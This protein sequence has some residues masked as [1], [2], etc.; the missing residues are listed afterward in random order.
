MKTWDHKKYKNTINGLSITDLDGDITV[1]SDS[2]DFTFKQGQNGKTE[3][4]AN[5][6]MLI[7]ITVPFMATS[8]QL[9][10]IE[11]MRIAD[12]DAAV[13]PFPWASAIIGGDY[14]LFGSA[15]IESIDPPNASIEATARNVVLKVAVE[16]EFRGR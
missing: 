5:R 8:P 11:A 12:L 14:K 4:S 2:P 15:T 1:E 3:R 13:G 10:I 9:S 7:T 6:N 16:S